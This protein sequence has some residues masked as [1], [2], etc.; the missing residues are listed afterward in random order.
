MGPFLDIAHQIV[1]HQFS[2]TAWVEFASDVA[3]LPW[4]PTLLAPLGLVHGAVFAI[5]QTAFPQMP[6]PFSAESVFS[7]AE[8]RC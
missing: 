1:T 6:L 4:A 8:T 7:V 2:T 5:L 3:L